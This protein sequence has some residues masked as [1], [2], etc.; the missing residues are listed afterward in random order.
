[1]QTKEE[2]ERLRQAIVQAMIANDGLTREQAEAEESRRFTRA[3]HRLL[4]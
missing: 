3:M 4:R 1:M 2:T